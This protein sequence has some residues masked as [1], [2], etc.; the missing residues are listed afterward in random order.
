MRTNPVP[1]RRCACPP[2]GVRPRTALLC[3]V[4]SDSQ[5][6]APRSPLAL[7]S[8]CSAC[9]SAAGELYPMAKKD[10][11]SFF[12]GYDVADAALL[13]LGEHHVL[14]TLH[15]QTQSVR[16]LLRVP[17][18][19]TQ[20]VRQREPSWA[21]RAAQSQPS[22]SGRGVG[23]W[24]VVVV[25]AQAA[26]MAVSRIHTAKREPKYQKEWPRGARVVTSFFEVLLLNAD[27]LAVPCNGKGQRRQ[28]RLAGFGSNAHVSCTS[29][30]KKTKNEER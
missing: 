27:V 15:P 5:S 14:H 26:I 23:V 13:L 19:P 20:H 8:C 7:F 18:R 24:L 3:P 28:D 22:A 10:L 6:P 9:L 2:Q 11:A 1:R 4:A 29:A 21:Q 12:K 16:L 25:C 17:S 30:K